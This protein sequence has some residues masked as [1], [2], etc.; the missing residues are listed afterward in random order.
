MCHCGSN[1]LDTLH[2]EVPIT[3]FPAYMRRRQRC[4]DSLCVEL[5][6]V[7]IGC[8]FDNYFLLLTLNLLTA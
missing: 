8:T 6:L 2:S 5:A 4:V 3:F 1:L 7:V